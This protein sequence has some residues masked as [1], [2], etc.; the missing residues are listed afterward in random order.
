M[1]SVLREGTERMSHDTEAAWV[2]SKVYAATTERGRYRIE[3]HPGETAVS[4][5]RNDEYVGWAY[6][7]GHAKECIEGGLT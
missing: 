3:T 2:E 1:R 5:Y 7:V 4:V 6:S